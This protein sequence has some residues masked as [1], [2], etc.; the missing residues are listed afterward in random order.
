MAFRQRAALYSLLF[1]AGSI[2]VHSQNVIPAPNY[3]QGWCYFCSDGDAPPLCNADCVTAIDKVCNSGQ[4]TLSLVY[5][6]NSCQVEYM[7]PP[8]GGKRQAADEPQTC[9]NYFNQ[10]LSACGKDASTPETATPS[11]DPKYCTSS[12]GGGTYGWNDDGSVMA[13]TNGRYKITTPNTNQCG[14]STA[15]WHLPNTQ[16]VEWN[17]SWVQP[18]DQVVL[19][20]NPPPPDSSAVAALNALPP[21]NPTCQTEVCDIFDNPYYAKSVVQPWPEP[22]NSQT[23]LRFRVVYEGWSTDDR[24]TRLFNALNARCG[25]WPGNFQPYLNGTEIRVADFDFNIKPLNPCACIPEAIYDASV[26][27]V[28]GRTAF[29]GITV[30]TD[31]QGRTEFLPLPGSGHDDLLRRRSLEGHGELDGI[32]GLF[33]F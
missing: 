16:V 8:D 20:T 32:S 15:S 29:C 19:D 13:N 5:V 6:Q 4:L 1:A 22:P 27:I 30:P 10:I 33:E 31:A 7:P 12:G 3:N 24:S 21:E 18:G 25:Q 2:L 9:T 23:K 14:Q 17:A 28:T 26:G 11:F